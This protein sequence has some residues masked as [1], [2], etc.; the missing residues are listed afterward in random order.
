MKKFSLFFIG[1]L[2]L[3]GAGCSSP[4]SQTVTPNPQPAT[5]KSDLIRVT[6]PLADTF[7]KSPLHIEGQALGS[8]YFEASFPIKLL[9][10]NGRPLGAATAKAQGEWM[11]NAFVPFKADLTFSVP[12]TDKGTLVLEKDNPSGLPQNADELRIPV[13]FDQKTRTIQLHYYDSSKDQ[14][15]T[16]NVMCTRNGLVAVE[17]QIPSTITPIQDAIN[18]LL[19]GKLTD[20]EKAQGVTTEYPLPG[21]VLKGASLKDGVLTLEFSD[22]Q[23][24]TSGGSCRSG[25]LWYQIEATAKQFPEVKTVKFIPDILFQP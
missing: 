13:K 5:D 7:V 8:W 17:R 25:V 2:L 6:T 20:G 10:A 11:V 15:A 9:D 21:V 14:D 19:Q 24:K 18:L 12:T 1:A 3:V 16:G 23:N 4:P 22:P